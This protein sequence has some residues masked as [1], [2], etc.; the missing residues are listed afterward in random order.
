[1]FVG[2]CPA[3]PDPRIKDLDGTPAFSYPYAVAPG[4]AGFTG[5]FA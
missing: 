1:V 2:G 4:G 3:V 5:Q